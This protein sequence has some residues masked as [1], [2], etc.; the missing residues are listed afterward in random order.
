MDHGFPKHD[1][2]F[3]NTWR[4]DIYISTRFRFGGFRVNF[5][6]QHKTSQNLSALSTMS[7]T[8]SFYEDPFFSQFNRLFDAAWDARYTDAANNRDVQAKESSKS[9]PL[10]P[11][12]VATLL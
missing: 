11:R 8:T 1:I 4:P 2:N 6:S 3:K 10:R 7:L 5:E 9:G 12:Y